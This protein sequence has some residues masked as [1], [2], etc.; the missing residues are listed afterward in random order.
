[1]ALAADQSVLCEAVTAG[2]GVDCGQ[3]GRQAT[4]FS[5]WFICVVSFYFILM[6]SMGV[7]LYEWIRGKFFKK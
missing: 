2:V 4:L 3:A 5:F 7:Y 6:S 1:M